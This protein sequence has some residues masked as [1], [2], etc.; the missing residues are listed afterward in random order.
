MQD[1]NRSYLRWLIIAGLIEG[2]ST[3]VLFF[4][5]M[6]LKYFADMPAAVSIAGPVHGFLFL[7]LVLMFWIGKAAVPLPTRLVV[8]GM[9]GAVIPFV[10]FIVDVPLYKML[11]GEQP[12][13]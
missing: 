9:L 2:L 13:S 8:W 7:G 11:Q 1:I 5:A 10:P 6:P 12:Q 4:V 3:L